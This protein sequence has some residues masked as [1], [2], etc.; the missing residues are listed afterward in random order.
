MPLM[1]SGEDT[2]IDRALDLVRHVI[3]RSCWSA[4][5]SQRTDWVIVLDLGQKH[6]RTMRLANPRLSFLQRTFEGEYSFLIECA[7]RLDGPDGVVASCFDENHPGGPMQKGLSA[8]EGRAVEDVSV[9]NTALDL[10]ITFAHGFVLRCLSTEVDP[11]RKRNNW[12]LWSP[13]G[14]VTIGPSGRLVIE[15][16]AEAEQ[17]HR[18]LK[19]SLAQEEDDV[20][21]RFRDK[22][23]SPHTTEDGTGQEDED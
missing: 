12:S 21:S 10:T 3:G 22:E 6:R 7:W 4:M 11:K 13:N 19:R 16:S 17:R 14:L 18:A 23:P 9:V 5:S 8:L 1:M 20:V 2:R 15:T